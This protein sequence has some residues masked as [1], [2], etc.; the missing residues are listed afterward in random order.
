MSQL[1][2]IQ[3]SDT[4]QA[5]LKRFW[6]YDEFLPMQESAIQTILTRRDSLTVMP[7]G[8]GKSLCY[9]LPAL[10]LPGTSIVISPLVA[11]MKDQVDNLKALGVSVAYL[12]SSQSPAEQRTVIDNLG[13]GDYKLLYVAPERFTAPNFMEALCNI[14]LGAF[15]VDEAHCISQWGHD[16]RPAYRAL[17]FLR[18][19]FPAIGIHAFTATATPSVQEDIGRS[20]HLQE[21]VVLIGDFMRPNL[22]YRVQYRTNTLKQVCAVIDRHPG[23]GGIIYC[24]SRKD[25]DGL[26]QLLKKQGYSVLPYHAG[27]SDA[28]RSDNQ[29]AF[30][31]EQVDIVV[32]TVAFGMGIDRSNVRYVIHTGMP[33]SVEHY[34]QEAGRAGRDRLMAECVLLYAGSDVMTWRSII[35]QSE[36]NTEDPTEQQEA[37]QKVA[38]AKLFE[39]SDYAQRVICRHRFLVE[40]FGQPFQQPTCGHCDYCLGEFETIADSVP[41]AQKILSCVYRVRQRFGTQHVAQVLQGA[42]TDKIRQ[43]E[44]DKLSTY[45]LLQAYDRKMIAQWIEQLVSEGF[46]EKEAAY[47]SLRLTEPGM[48]LLKNEGTVTLVRPVMAEKTVTDKKK[49]TKERTVMLDLRNEQ[50]LS[51]F[52]SLRALR[53]QIALEKKMPPYVIFH[54]ST[55]KELV[56]AKPTS[57]EDFG[58]VKGVGEAKCREYGSRFVEVINQSMQA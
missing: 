34:Q 25:V 32:A 54:D 26:S 15:I 3:P 56:L 41:I 29:A 1:I 36:N 47:G 20:L 51:L 33:K 28:V 46:L 24:I 21:P 9:Q 38:L 18:Q 14:T 16:F 30:T 31:N 52:Q 53:R 42:S 45:A 11:L 50:D 23:E 4:P 7:T 6:G 10:L 40:Y 19:R 58:G 2:E 37:I 44:H 5:V 12:N 57:L 48:R 35:S 27:L 39:M 8:G 17:S 22:L 49:K 43:F 55:L 13:R